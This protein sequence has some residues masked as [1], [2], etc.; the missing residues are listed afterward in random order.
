MASAAPR[1]P[2]CATP[3]SSGARF[4]P[5]CGVGLFE[6]PE[7]ETIKLATILFADIVG[8]TARAEFLSPDDARAEVA[9]FLQELS[10]EVRAEGGTI[11]RFEGDALMAD[12]GIPK[13]REDDPLR[14]A[15]AAT[16]MLAQVEKWNE[17]H[18]DQSPLRLR[19]G[20]NTG[21]VSAGGALGSGLLVMGDAVNVAAR[22]Q[23][24]AEANTILIGERTARAVEHAYLLEQLPPQMVKGKT[25]PLSLWQL[26][27]ERVLKDRSI[28]GLVEAP[29]IGRT[30][31]L[32]QMTARLQ[33]VEQSR[34]PHWITIAGD[35]GMGK[36]RLLAEFV[37]QLAPR[38][39]YAVGHCLPHDQAAPLA[40]LNEILMAHIGTTPTDPLPLVEA[41]LSKLLDELV[42]EN[43]L[44]DRELSA[45]ALLVTMGFTPQALE[46]AVDPRTIHEALIS[47]WSSILTSVAAERPLVVVIEDLHWGDPALLGSLTEIC[48]ATRGPVLFVTSSRP[49]LLETKSA[50]D[51]HDQHHEIVRLTPLD[52]DQTRELITAIG[53][54]DEEAQELRERIGERAEGNP[55]F[56]EELMRRLVQEGDLVRVAE[57]WRIN[58]DVQLDLPDSIN[59]LLHARMDLLD[60]TSTEVLRAAAVVG[61]FFTQDD[62]AHLVSRPDATQTIDA[63]RAM[64]FIA[65][66][67]R[68]RF[69][70]AL[71]Q[72]IVYDTIPATDRARLHH[73][74]AQL[75]E[76]GAADLASVAFPL[77]HHYG[78]AFERLRE[79]ELRTKARHYSMIASRAAMASFALKTAEENG[80]RAID[81]SESSGD[82]LEALENLGDICYLT[83]NGDGAWSSYL[84]IYKLRKAEEGGD[85]AAIS[86]AA[87]RAALT[88]SRFAGTL[89]QEPPVEKVKALI[90]EG[91][92]HAEKAGDLR[93]RALLLSS[94]AS[95]QISGRADLTPQ[96][97]E[98]ASEA[99]RI[100]EELDDAV[101]LSGTLD[102]AGA[103][104]IPEGRWGEVERI[105]RR[106]LD[107][108]PQLSDAREIA[109]T[110][111]MM[112]WSCAYVGRYAEAVQHATSAI[113]FSRDGDAVAYAHGLTW[114]VCASFMTGDWDQALK[115][116][117]ELQE[118][119]EQ[120]AR[121][122]P[123]PF[124][125]RGFAAG[126]L[127]HDLRDEKEEA[128][129]C[130]RLIGKAESKGIA[131]GAH[132]PLLAKL[133]VQRG[134][135]DRALAILD[136]DPGG[137]SGKKEE[138]KGLNLE[139]R[140]E[141]LAAG[142]FWPEARSVVDEARSWSREA[143]L[144]AL[145]FFADRLEGRAEAAEANYVIAAQLL[146][147]SMEGFMALD[148][149]WEEAWSQFLLGE[150][151]AGAGK[152]QESIAVAGESLNLFTKLGSVTHMEAAQGLLTRLTAPQVSPS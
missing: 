85:P 37:D 105:E 124:T 50:L 100:A 7:L 111:G 55:L 28:A 26:G 99:V 125:L 109:D 93:A 76:E 10:D 110:Y 65:G 88:A 107:L 57:Q 116:K 68:L 95:L 101:L 150:V 77:A 90:D 148:A 67:S 49:T 6:A 54:Q 113:E 32:E 16:K 14:A 13:A 119:M 12:F 23:D 103:C 9:G 39:S 152:T 75:I 149:P 60:P 69:K 81:L 78:T 24:L 87:S 135:I 139:V 56:V 126:A 132:E 140:C 102:V 136:S 59:A 121:G 117:K 61:R 131:R 96:A 34:Q 144:L 82:T 89:H 70:H 128:N 19:I 104:L 112:A 130:V 8:S 47:T 18:P 147:R 80:R 15:R 142:E 72:E 35:P 4:C 53:L 146:R 62:V 123:V 42:T 43:F 84:E 71:I 114:R 129:R 5:S 3:L 38:A 98:A 1:C 133:C 21:P 137:H 44:E 92:K 45:H 106:R 58:T 79:D 86:R 27:E 143:G 17:T 51:L 52:D 134:D 120:D 83:G 2:T 20:I 41:A 138:T 48:E 74:T 40:P 25:E 118:L 127:C 108:L 73:K 36:T 151:L 145:E 94:R 46:E 22:I 91:L 29:M 141:A 33:E 63:L 66:R 122:S 11:D 30:L 115:D 64:G 31:E 97:K